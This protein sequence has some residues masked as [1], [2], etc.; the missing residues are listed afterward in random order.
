LEYL[1]D[2]GAGVCEGYA[3]GVAGLEASNALIS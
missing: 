2:A 3:V 1:P